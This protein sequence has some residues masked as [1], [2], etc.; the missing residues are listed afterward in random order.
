MA[1]VRVQVDSNILAKARERILAT[2]VRLTNRQTIE[3]GLGLI[4]SAH[5]VDLPMGTLPGNGP[6]KIKP[7]AVKDTT[8]ANTLAALEQANEMLETI[9]YNILYD[10][11]IGSYLK[12][13]D[14]HKTA[15]ARTLDTTERVAE[16]ARIKLP[17]AALAQHAGGEHVR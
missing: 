7:L 16:L 13:A 4:L 14:G 6:A 12:N 1:V 10:E 17:Q 2:N 8:L 11:R 15:I 3:H 5:L 9:R